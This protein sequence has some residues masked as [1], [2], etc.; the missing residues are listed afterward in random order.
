MKHIL[1]ILFLT[2]I[3]FISG[4]IFMI[5]RCGYILELK[6]KKLNKYFSYFNFLDSLLICKERNYKLRDYFD[7]NNI[8]TVAIYGMGKIGKHLK[9]ELD[10][11]GIK[12][13]YVIDEGDSG[14][15]CKEEHYNL[16][17]DLP[18]VDVV[19][20]TVIDEFEDIKNKLM[21]NN[22]MLKVVSIDNILEYWFK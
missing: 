12:I 21:D 5:Y 16:R 17:D 20:V 4:V 10:K 22:K 15:Y 2:V 13:A 8:E 14:I 18:L 3:G 7:E 6:Q 9:Y 19:I 1:C 11:M